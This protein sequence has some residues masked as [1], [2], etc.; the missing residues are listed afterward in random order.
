[1]HPYLESTRHA[2]ETLF[3]GIFRE[4]RELA[5]LRHELAAAEPGAE[6]LAR[7][8]EDFVRYTDLN[9]D[10]EGIGQLRTAEAWDASARVGHLRRSVEELTQ[11]IDAKEQATIALCGA[12]LQ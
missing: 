8:A 6:A 4:E 12:L 11:S 9:D 1:M 2:A 7:S 10:D 5:Q 3:K